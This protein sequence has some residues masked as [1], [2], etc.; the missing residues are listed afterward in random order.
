VLRLRFLPQS[1]VTLSATGLSDDL[2]WVPTL[3]AIVGVIAGLHR[4][5]ALFPWVMLQTVT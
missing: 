5:L 4:A 1:V 3:A 2:S